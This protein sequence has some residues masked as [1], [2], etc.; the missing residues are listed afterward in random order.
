MYETGFMHV[1]HASLSQTLMKSSSIFLLKV[2]QLYVQK[3][4][5]KVNKYYQNIDEKPVHVLA[6]VLHLYYKLEYIKMTWGGHEEQEHERA[7]NNLNAKDWHDEALKVVETTMEDYWKTH[8]STTSI[9]HPLATAS[10][11]STS[12]TPSHDTT[13]LESAFD[14]HRH[15]LLEQ[16]ILDHDAGWV[17][18]LQRY[19]K[20]MPDVLKSTVSSYLRVLY[21]GSKNCP[22]TLKAANLKAVTKKKNHFSQQLIEREGWPLL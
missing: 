4:L 10:V 15:L 21:S 16:A 18:E 13:T 17:A 11:A 5:D 6:L 12:M 20:D 1:T 22:N 8:P 9:M 7:A 3:G 19:L 2:N 14:H